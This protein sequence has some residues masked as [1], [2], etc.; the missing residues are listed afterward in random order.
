ME[1]D[2]EAYD[3][4]GASVIA[5]DDGLVLYELDELPLS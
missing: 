5:T 4:E 1:P 3:V 2:A